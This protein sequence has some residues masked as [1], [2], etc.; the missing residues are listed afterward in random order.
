MSEETE[1]LLRDCDVYTY[2]ASSGPGGMNVNKRA[3]AVR[4]T[5]RPTGLKASSKS[6]RTQAGNK[7]EAAKRLAKKIVKAN[8]VEV[9]RVPT[10]TPKGLKEKRLTDKRKNSQKK[11]GRKPV[12]EEN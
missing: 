11:D 2:A 6:E 7:R 1:K 3:T 12:R 9:K 4:L 10:G 5:H 8:E